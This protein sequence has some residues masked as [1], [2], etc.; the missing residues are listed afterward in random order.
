ME[1][2]F[3]LVQLQKASNTTN[4]F[5]IK[6]PIKAYRKNK[7]TLNK[8]HKNFPCPCFAVVKAEWRVT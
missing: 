3:Q 1:T 4:G 2:Y 6:I 8:T 7:T 5:E